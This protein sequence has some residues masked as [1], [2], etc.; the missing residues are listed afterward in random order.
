MNFNW[1]NHRFVRGALFLAATF[2]P[3][4]A[5]LSLIVLPIRDLLADRD[6]EIARNVQMLA[7]FTAIAAYKPNLPPAARLRDTPDEYFKG[8]SQG[9]AT[10]NLQARLKILSEASGARLRSVQGLPAESQGRLSYIGARLDIFGS[11]EAVQRAANAIEDARPYFFVTASVIK[12][13]TQPMVP[14][15]QAAEPVIDAQLD[16]FAAF[17]QEGAP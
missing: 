15:G 8:P 1:R 5:G 17:Q 11:I 12:R 13:S 6:A 16:V 3:V 9:V 7:R 2:L 4:F 10:A 14:G